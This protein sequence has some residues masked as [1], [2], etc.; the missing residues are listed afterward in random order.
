M[1]KL[2]QLLNEASK[3][4]KSELSKLRGK[5]IKNATQFKNMIGYNIIDL[6]LSDGST[7]KIIHPKEVTLG[8]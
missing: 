8:K 4:G 6:E 2:K 7:L 1:I 5:K 3:L